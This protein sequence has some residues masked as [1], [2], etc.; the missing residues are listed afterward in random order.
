R[1]ILTQQL[2]GER[3]Q[4]L[5]LGRAVGENPRL[6]ACHS[7]PH[8][9]PTPLSSPPQQR[10]QI[11]GVAAGPCDRSWILH[12]L[13]V[14]GAAAKVVQHYA[15]VVQ[16]QPGERKRTRKAEQRQALLPDEE[17]RSAIDCHVDLD[18]VALVRSD[19]SRLAG[20][21]RPKAP[22]RFVRPFGSPGNESA[23]LI[24]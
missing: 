8:A 3:E 5:L 12:E 22:D 15:H 21:F 7:D 19:R 13:S 1:S 9:R 16:Y 11:T 24:E 20:Q 18:G 4:P 2:S 23:R 6:A 10:Q 17:N 14:V